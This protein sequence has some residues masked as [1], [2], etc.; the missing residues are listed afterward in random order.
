MFETIISEIEEE[1]NI[2]IF[3]K[4]FWLQTVLDQRW[5]FE[6]EEGHILHIREKYI[7]KPSWNVLEEWEHRYMYDVDIKSLIRNSI[8]NSAVESHINL[9]KQKKPLTFRKRLKRHKI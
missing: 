2:R 4:N 1:L 8:I 9:Q 5:C 3:K 7:N 6:T